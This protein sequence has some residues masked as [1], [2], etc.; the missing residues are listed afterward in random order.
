MG[1]MNKENKFNGLFLDINIGKTIPFMG[2]RSIQ[3]TQEFLQPC[4][5]NL[6]FTNIKNRC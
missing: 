5:V 6:C 3:T 1:C 4:L 2:S